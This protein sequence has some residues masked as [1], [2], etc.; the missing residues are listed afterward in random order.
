MRWIRNKDV[1]K[2]VTESWMKPFWGLSMYRIFAKLKC[3]KK[4]EDWQRVNN[5]NTKAKIHQLNL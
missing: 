2:V 3:R 5:Q 4:L 1:E